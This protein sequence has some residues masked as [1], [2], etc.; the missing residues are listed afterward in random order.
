MY[1]KKLNKSSFIEAIKFNEE[2]NYDNFIKIDHIVRLIN[3]GLMNNTKSKI[4]TK[5]SSKQDKELYAYLEEFVNELSSLTD[6]YRAIETQKI[7]FKMNILDKFYEILG[8]KIDKTDL[9]APYSKD[10]STF[11]LGCIQY[12]FNKLM[13]HSNIYDIYEVVEGD[14]KKKIPQSDKNMFYY[15]HEV[16]SRLIGVCKY[17]EDYVTKK[18]IEIYNKA[19]ETLEHPSATM[20]KT[21]LYKALF[22]RQ[23][24]VKKYEDE[25]AAKSKKTK[26]SAA[27]KP[28]SKKT[29][30]KKSTTKKPAIKK[31]SDVKAK[32]SSRLGPNGRKLL[33]K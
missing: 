13:D 9:E 21:V 33:K 23:Y 20:E 18:Y 15:F 2:N 31:V 17:I 5:T 3:I 27:K 10:F 7:T 26:K 25:E 16:Y 30:A 8:V 14:Y 28:T 12:M 4:I 24:Y 22:N 11:E 32:T 29:T 19:L 6:Q 1:N